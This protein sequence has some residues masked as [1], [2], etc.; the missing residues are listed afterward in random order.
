[1]NEVIKMDIIIN[2]S[3]CGNIAEDDMILENDKFKNT[4]G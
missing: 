4:S 3:H 2:L 1:M